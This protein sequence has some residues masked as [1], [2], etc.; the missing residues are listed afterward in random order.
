MNRLT[1]AAFAALA[2]LAPS[3]AGSSEVCPTTPNSAGAGAV[4]DYVHDAAPELAAF[5][6]TGCP[7]PSFGALIYS[8]L[9]QPPAPF[10][11]GSLCV[12]PFVAG[13][14]MMRAVRVTPEG[15]AAFTVAEG[16][17]AQ[18]W[19]FAVGCFA[20]FMYRDELAGG[21]LFNLSNAI[22]TEAPAP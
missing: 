18:A 12:R 22:R 10:G 16:Q 15:V 20:Q 1:A 2:L 21:A 8:S 11:N 4:L 17:Q 5:N 7:G 19:P 9:S 6:V 3:F 14:G 13:S